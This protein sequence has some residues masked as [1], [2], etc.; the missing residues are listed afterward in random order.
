MNEKFP[1]VALKHFATCFRT[2][3]PWKVESSTTSKLENPGLMSTSANMDAGIMV[4][5]TGET[6]L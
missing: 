2:D 5:T 3:V 4:T 1:G 6:K